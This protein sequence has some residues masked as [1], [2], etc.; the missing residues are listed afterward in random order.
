MTLLTDWERPF[1][2]KKAFSIPLT[3]CFVTHR[4]YRHTWGMSKWLIS[5]D[6]FFFHSVLRCRCSSLTNDLHSHEIFMNEKLFLTIRD[7]FPLLHQFFLKVNSTDMQG[8]DNEKMLNIFLWWMKKMF[9]PVSCLLFKSLSLK[10]ILYT[11]QRMS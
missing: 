10:D 1:F 9:T 4:M 6:T 11:T 8:G 3:N 5:T 2:S 7:F